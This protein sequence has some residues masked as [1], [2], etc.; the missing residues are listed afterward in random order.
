MLLSFLR[1]LYIC[2]IGSS[3]P[4]HT[5]DLCVLESRIAKYFV[6]PL[7]ALYVLELGKRLALMLV[8]KA[9][10]SIGSLEMIEK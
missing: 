2:V 8:A 4:T 7:A 3:N 9:S 10:K 5:V 6:L 1:L